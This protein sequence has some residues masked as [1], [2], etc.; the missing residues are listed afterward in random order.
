LYYDGKTIFNALAEQYDAYRPHY[1]A[2]ALSF[3]VTLGELDRSSDVA[4]VGSGTGRIAL[5]LAKYVRVV[6]AVDTATAMLERL[7]VVAREAWLSNIRTIEA[8]GEDTTLP[9]ESVDMGV[10]A[11]SFHWMDKPMA[12]KEMNRILRPGKDLVVMWN[13]T[14]NTEDPYYQ[15][16]VSL[17]KEYNPNYLGASDIVS[18]DFAP[19]IASSGLFGPVEKF[20]FPFPLHYSAES[21]I[22]FLLSKSYV[23]VGIPQDKLPY[24]IEGA[25]QTLRD[26]FSHGKVEEKYETVLLVAKK[27]V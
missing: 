10:M 19:A 23:G 11:Q 7:A 5:E 26:H 3:L 27:I 20:T 18:K 21:Y 1:P 12:L 14:T 2:E 25:H 16:I 9:D 22:G 8:P 13:E 15:T 17:I 6:Y 24:F 4:D